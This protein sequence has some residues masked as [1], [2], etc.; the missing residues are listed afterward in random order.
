MSEGGSSP[1][2]AAI[3]RSPQAPRR[4]PAHEVLP[5]AGTQVQ[6]VAA[7]GPSMTPTSIMPEGIIDKLI[8]QYTET[9]A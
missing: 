6:P 4:M 8:C 2:V 9:A 7:S 5:A 1:A 3:G